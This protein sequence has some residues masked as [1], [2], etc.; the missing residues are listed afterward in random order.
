MRVFCDS[1][2]D[3]LP[4]VPVQPVCGRHPDAVGSSA[5]VCIEGMVSRSFNNLLSG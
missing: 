3:G 2:F 1:P 4:P 5:A